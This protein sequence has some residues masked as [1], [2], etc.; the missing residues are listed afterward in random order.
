[1]KTII[2]GGSAAGMMTAALLDF[3]KE[4][5]LLEK[6]ERMGKK[7]YI[8]G[9]GRCNLTNATVGEEF[10]ENLVSNKRFFYSAF[11]NFSNFDMYAFLEE[12]GLSLKI[13]RGER[14]FP[15]SDR[16]QDV[17]ETLER[18]A[19]KSGIKIRKNSEVKEVLT[20]DENGVKKASGVRL[21][22]GSVLMADNVV[23][24]TGGLSYPTTGSTGATASQGKQGMK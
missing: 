9:K 12:R 19:R 1:M 6:N 2:S 24:A 4:N 20:E 5:I 11:N 22:D 21:S 13:E 16:A 14:V 10:M 17:I 15:E 3:N 23:I 7:I 18:A 8:T